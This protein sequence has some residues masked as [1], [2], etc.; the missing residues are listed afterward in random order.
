MP[1]LSGRTLD[2]AIFNADVREFESRRERPCL[3][4]LSFIHTLRTEKSACPQHPTSF[5]GAVA[6]PVIRLFGQEWDEVVIPVKTHPREGKNNLQRH[7]WT[8]CGTASVRER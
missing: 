6:C 8:N 2:S 5:L 1:W 4:D 3:F 7:L